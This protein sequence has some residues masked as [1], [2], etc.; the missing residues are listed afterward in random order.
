MK[1]HEAGG[2]RRLAGNIA[3]NCIGISMRLLL[4]SYIFCVDL[5]SI[6]IEKKFKLAFTLLLLDWLFR[7]E[8][9]PQHRVQ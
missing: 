6:R 4:P 9:L 7:V 1:S 8:L 5:V 2:I 3:Y